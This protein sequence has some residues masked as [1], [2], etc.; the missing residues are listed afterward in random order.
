M[1]NYKIE[2]TDTGYEIT[3]PVVS[4]EKL[5]Y[6]TLDEAVAKAKELETAA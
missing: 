1:A 4:E 2:K 3:I 6:A 5:N